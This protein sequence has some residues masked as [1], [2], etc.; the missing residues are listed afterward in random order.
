MAD[1]PIG[2]TVVWATSAFAAEI[3]EMSIEGMERTAIS[4]SHY[5]STN[6]MEYIAAKLKDTPELN[7]T[8]NFDTDNLPLPVETVAEVVTVTWPVP[9]GGSTAATLIGTAFTTANTI[10]MGDG[11]DKMTADITVKYDGRTTPP[12]FTAST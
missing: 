4:V 9:P 7:M 3:T 11:E 5:G 12:A 10:E 8:I 1:T 6:W 2:T